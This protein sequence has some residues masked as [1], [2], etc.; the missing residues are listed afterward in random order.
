MSNVITYLGVRMEPSWSSLNVELAVVTSH[1]ARANRSQASE[2]LS[3]TLARSLELG[4]IPLLLVKVLSECMFTVI[5]YL[6]F[7]YR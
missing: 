2:W 6:S 4:G 1:P 5:P 7:Q 3:P